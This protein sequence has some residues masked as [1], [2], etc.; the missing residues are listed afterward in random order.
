MNPKYVSIDKIGVNKNA[1]DCAIEALILQWKREN[2]DAPYKITPWVNNHG[3][4]TA[5]IEAA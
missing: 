2:G 5:S 4:Y 3:V 1:E